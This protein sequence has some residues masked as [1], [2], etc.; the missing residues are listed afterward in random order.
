MMKA[1]SANEW[2]CAVT[3]NGVAVI[4]INRPEAKN[5]VNLDVAEGIAAAVEELDARDVA[6]RAC[7]LA[8]S[9]SRILKTLTARGLIETARD[10]SDGRRTM[11]RLSTAG[12]AF[13]ER[14]TP[15]SA[16]S[17]ARLEKIIGAGRMAELIDALAETLDLLD[18]AEES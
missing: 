5:A 15:E 11:I 17:Y 7:I 10:S 14:L 12:N 2:S 13:I 3:A 8:P 16:A 1:A 6:E 18:E 4:T 9:L